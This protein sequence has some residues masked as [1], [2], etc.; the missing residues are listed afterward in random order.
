MI[1]KKQK[2]CKTQFKWKKWMRVLKIRVL[3]KNLKYL[4]AKE[5]LMMQAER[6]D[7]A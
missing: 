7:R 1:Y 6:L 3:K 5:A 4:L 2:Y